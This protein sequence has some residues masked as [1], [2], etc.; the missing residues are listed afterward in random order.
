MNTLQDFFT[1]TKGTTYVVAFLF[2]VAAIGFW[3]L[4]TD[5]EERK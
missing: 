5:R 3:L 2:L 4:L 1:L